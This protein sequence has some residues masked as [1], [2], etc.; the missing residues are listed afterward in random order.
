M[1]GRD[2][3]ETAR[4]IRHDGQ[5]DRTPLVLMFSPQ[6]REKL[7][8]RGAR[9][10]AVLDVYLVKPVTASMRLDAI[11]AARQE[12]GVHH[13]SAGPIDPRPMCV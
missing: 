7:E 5:V 12:H 2:G 13:A 8:G 10:Q 6:C 4:H 9:G 11:V 3:L 1:P